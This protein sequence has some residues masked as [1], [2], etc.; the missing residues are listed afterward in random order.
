MKVHKYELTDYHSVGI[1]ETILLETRLYIPNYH[2][3]LISRERD[4]YFSNVDIEII[5]TSTNPRDIDQAKR[6]IDGSNESNARYL[7]IVE[8]P[9]NIVQEVISDG[10]LLDEVKL[11][12]RNSSKKLCEL[13]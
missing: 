3:V 11:R 5:R 8:L 6:C 2:T 4:K 10:R 12:L 9:D 7:G 13:I 1:G